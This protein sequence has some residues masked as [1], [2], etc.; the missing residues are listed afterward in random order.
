MPRIKGFV[1]V[2]KK[3]LYC[4]P[5]GG[6]HTYTSIHTCMCAYTHIHTL[7]H[8]RT[9]TRA[10]VHTGTLK[11]TVEVRAQTA[12]IPSLPPLCESQALNLKLGSTFTP[13]A[14]SLVSRHSDYTITTNTTGY[15]SFLS[16]QHPQAFP[17]VRCQPTRGLRSNLSPI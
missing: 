12:E 1:F 16:A 4:V 6:Q 10:H 8:L 2:L 13:S 15:F 14:I 5:W 9:H 7:M 11:H 17:P 3:K